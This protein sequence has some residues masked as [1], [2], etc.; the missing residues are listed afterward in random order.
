MAYHFESFGG[1]ALPIYNIQTDQSGGVAVSTLVRTI[2]GTIDTRP[3]KREVPERALFSMRGLLA[4]LSVAGAAAEYWLTGDG[5]RIVIGG[6]DVFIFSAA[7]AGSTNTIRMQ[8]EA[9][10]AQIGMLGTLVRVPNTGGDGNQSLVA[11]L[12]SVRQQTRVEEHRARLEI[13][14]A[15][16]SA[17]PYWHGVLKTASRSGSTISASNG[18]NA[19]VRDAVLTVTGSFVTTDV[20]VSAPG[21]NFTWSG[22]LPAGQTLVIQGNTVNLNGVPST[23]TIGSGHTR[24]VLVELE[25]GANA[26][27][28]TGGASAKLDWYD[29]WQ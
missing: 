21:V 1:V 23:V 25:A 13:D 22:S 17:S 18:G 10:R 4:D 14:L 2:N 28:V 29:A 3:G 7:T 19:P 11:R 9:L 16:E 15:F 20:I 24:D 27:T 8:L 26:L 5:D 12:L 6:P